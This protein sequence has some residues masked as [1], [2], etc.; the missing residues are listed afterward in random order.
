MEARVSISV[1]YLHDRLLIVIP[2]HEEFF[3]VRAADLHGFVSQ[4]LS[5]QPMIIETQASET[6]VVNYDQQVHGDCK[7]AMHEFNASLRS[8]GGP[9]EPW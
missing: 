8:Y 5:G 4:V 7:S 1:V 3:C 2:L 9:R 6:S